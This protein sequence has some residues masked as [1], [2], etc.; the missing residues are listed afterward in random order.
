MEKKMYKRKPCNSFG[1]VSAFTSLLMLSSV[2]P[3]KLFAQ[4][5]KPNPP[6]PMKKG[7]SQDYAYMAKLVFRKGRSCTLFFDRGRYLISFQNGQR[8]RLIGKSEPEVKWELNA[9]EKTAEVNQFYSQRMLLYVV[10]KNGINFVVKQSG[11]DRELLEKYILIISKQRDIVRNFDLLINKVDIHTLEFRRMYQ[12][13]GEET[14]ANLK[15]NIYT[16]VDNR[17]LRL[18]I[19]PRSGYVLHQEE[20]DDNSHEKNPTPYN[21]KVVEFQMLDHIDSSKFEIPPDY[22]VKLKGVFQNISLPKSA[23]RVVVSDTLNPSSSYLGFD[24]KEYFKGIEDEKK[25]PRGGDH[26]IQ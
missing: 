26:R 25:R 17:G 15:C 4:S 24:L 18:S 9:R 2:V 13:T 6:N 23:K 7:S 10:K 16:P 3:V 8:L 20:I 12:L 21:V 19:E 14:L 22:T 1:L 11:L 5:E